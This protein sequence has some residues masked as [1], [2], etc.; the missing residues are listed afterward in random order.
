MQKKRDKEGDKKAQ[1][2]KKLKERQRREQKEMRDKRKNK[3]SFQPVS[4]TALELV[5]KLDI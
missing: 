2:G 1:K 4:R 5:M 3:T